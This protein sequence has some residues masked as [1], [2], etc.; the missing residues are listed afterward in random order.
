MGIIAWADYLRCWEFMA[1]Q[2]LGP[3]RFTSFHTSCWSDRNWSLIATGSYKLAGSKYGGWY[4][5]GSCWQCW[6]CRHKG[7]WTLS[8]LD[9]Q[10][11]EEHNLSHSK[12]SMWAALLWATR[13]AGSVGWHS[14]TQY[15]WLYET[16]AQGWFFLHDPLSCHVSAFASAG[17]PTACEVMRL[18]LKVCFH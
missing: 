18:E 15:L 9:S 5:S 17:W 8:H 2:V 6:S 13:E 7:W 16:G 1:F 4:P 12:R 3:A 10:L 11:D 14:F